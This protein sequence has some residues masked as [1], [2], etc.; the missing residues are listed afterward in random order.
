VYA[1]SISHPLVREPHGYAFT[2]PSKPKPILPK[3][4]K[5]ML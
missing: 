3:L 1:R 4:K 2:R 5:W